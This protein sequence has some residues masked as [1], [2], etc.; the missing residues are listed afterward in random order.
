MQK[1]EIDKMIALIEEGKTFEAIAVDD[2]FSIKIDRYLPYCCTAIHDGSNLRKELLDRIALDEYS[3][4][5]EEDPFT[6]AFISSMPIT[7]IGHDSRYEYDLNRTLDTCVYEEAWG[8]KIWK[9]KLLPKE[10]QLSKRKHSNYYKVTHALITKLESLFDGCIVYDIHSYNK[11]RWDRKVP[12]FNIGVERVDSKYAGIIENW[13]ASLSEIKIENI[14][15]VSAINDVFYGKGYNLEYITSHFSKTL[16][17]ATEVK[18]VYCNELTGASYPKII[19]SLQQGLK[20]A[21]STNANVFSQDFTSW[22]HKTASKLLGNKIED[23]VQKVDKG[24]YKLLRNFELLAYINPAN[25]LSEKRK[26]FKS[27]FTELPN[28]K[29]R[30]IRIDGYRLKQELSNLS[31]QDIDDISIRNLY[32]AVINS[33]FDKIDLLSTLGTKKFFYN[34]LLYFGRPTKTDIQNAHYLLH[35]PHIPTEPKRSPSLGSEQLVQTF[36][37]TLEHYGFESKIELS[38]KII[39]RAMVL[40]ARKTILVRPDAKFTRSE[41]NALAEHEI[42]VHMVT[43]MNARSQKLKLFNLG[44]PVNTETQEGLAI[45][46]E[47]LSGNISM[48]R[49]QRLA[50]R[51]IVV[52]M[53]CNGADFNECFH[54]LIANHQ[55]DQSEAFSLV[56]RIFRGGGFTKD[57]LYL[58]GFVKILRFWENGNNL[59]PLLVGKTSLNF[60]STI[61]EMIER[62]LVEKPKFITQSFIDPKS[63]HNNEVYEYILSGLK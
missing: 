11:E 28:F 43:T 32:E 63:E 51:V 5:Y 36:K 57:H 33:H 56:T 29:Y 58:S 55:I 39:S 48:K 41:I 52:D 21:I 54:Y 40:N 44:L 23:S 24:L 4:W 10:K 17:L 2:S 60:H 42:G 19:K 38:S 35:L 46:S 30:P 53:M 13:R 31:I 61:S 49:L 3:R 27:K 14:E 59:E 18:K 45:L 26:Y 9:K 20:K 7:L 37:E 25:H 34:S 1:L 22:N 62:E 8:T 47:Y 6:G 15:N 12:L 50:L 16:V